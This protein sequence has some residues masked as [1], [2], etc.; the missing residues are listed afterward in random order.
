M[1][2]KANKIIG[3]LIDTKTIDSRWIIINDNWITDNN[4]YLFNPR[5][6]KAH[7][8]VE[9]RYQTVFKDTLAFI[10]TSTYDDLQ[11]GD[12][13]WGGGAGFYKA[14]SY[15]APTMEELK[16]LINKALDNGS[17]DSGMGYESLIGATMNI[18]TKTQIFVE[19][20]WFTN[21]EYQVEHFGYKEIPDN[22]IELIQEEAENVLMEF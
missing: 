22:K 10:K 21:T 16:E 17:I 9:V 2:R 13:I 18:C 14:R 4:K 12:I 15:S 19:D 6:N 11:I 8:I 3:I 20:K 1:T 5:T 7:L